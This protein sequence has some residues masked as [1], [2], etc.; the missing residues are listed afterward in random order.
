M[1]GP[2]VWLRNIAFEKIYKSENVSLFDGCESLSKEGFAIFPNKLDQE[3]I[4]RLRDDFASLQDKKQ[5]EKSGQ[6]AGR[7]YANGSI[8]KLA[9]YYINKFR[10]IAEAYFGSNRIRCEL[11]MYQKSWPKTD[12]NDVPGGEFHED[13]NKRNMKFFIYLTDVCESNGP[14]C[15]V[16]GT[17]SLKRSEKYLRWLLWEIFR[18][19]RYLYGFKLNIE[20]C[21]KE[22]VRIVGPAGL[23]FCAD[24]TGY[25]RA[26]TPLVGE[27]EVF[28]VSYTRV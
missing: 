24:T 2:W 13:D 6:L 9:T 26:S 18:N 21:L 4:K 22:E 7:I 28:V 14:F 11:T 23:T 8:S 27:R 25:H 10:P 20:Q 1:I 15:Y 19:R 3:E 16:P 17:Q 12:I 5:F